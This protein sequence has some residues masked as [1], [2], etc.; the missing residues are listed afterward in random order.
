[1][2]QISETKKK[3]EAINMQLPISEIRERDWLLEPRNAV[4]TKS[5]LYFLYDANKTL[6][7]I[8]WSNHMNNRVKD[9]VKGRNYSKRFSDEIKRVE[10]ISFADLPKAFDLVRTRLNLDPN[11]RFDL[12]S[13]L[14]VLMDPKYNAHNPHLYANGR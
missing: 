4:E 5:G 12:E 10:M 6:L 9:H 2:R 11:K 3:K 7:Y 14:I 8:G 13:A 1:L